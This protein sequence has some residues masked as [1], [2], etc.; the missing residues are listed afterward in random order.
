MW[1]FKL[2]CEKFVLQPFTRLLRSIAL[3]IFNCI[4]L[5]WTGCWLAVF[6]LS[7]QRRQVNTIPGFTKCS[8]GE[9]CHFICYHRSR[10]RQVHCPW[11][12]T[13]LLNTQAQIL[14]PSNL[15]SM[16]SLV[17]RRLRHRCRTGK[18]FLVSHSGCRR[19]LPG[20]RCFDDR[21][22]SMSRRRR[23]RSWLN[24]ISE[25]CALRISNSSRKALEALS[26]DSTRRAE[27]EWR[28]WRRRGH[29]RKD[30][31]CSK[32]QDVPKG[33]WAPKEVLW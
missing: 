19:H 10:K 32:R 13:L 14:V 23:P 26:N 1:L 2:G 20:V 8:L 16:I 28:N 11:C 29:S 25:D 21:R 5:A 18:R 17:W 12:Q 33:D 31:Q 7:R 27:P 15:K 6:R 3:Q 4:E 22:S 24:I 30:L 9:S